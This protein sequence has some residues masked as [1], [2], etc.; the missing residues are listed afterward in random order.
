[1]TTPRRRM[2]RAPKSEPRRPSVRLKRMLSWGAIL[3][4]VGGGCGGGGKLGT[5][6]LS[7][8]AKSLQSEAAEGALLAQD[9]ASGRTTRIYTREQS[10]DL[11]GAAS[12]T[13]STLKAA[14][15]APALQSRVRQLA[16]LA[17]QL[18]AN[19]K[20]LGNASKDEAR[21]LARELDAASRASQ[22]IGEG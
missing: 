10:S 15:T 1:M 17:G 6:A 12:R 14:K 5:K 2:S 16:I 9:A 3:V 18:G 22:K 11:S 21:A 13:E 8:E 7:R 4:L 19:L 20:R